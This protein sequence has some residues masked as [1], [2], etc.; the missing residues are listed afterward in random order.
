MVIAA[1]KGAPLTPLQLQKALFLLGQSYPGEVGRDFYDFQPY[2][3][4]PF[5]VLVYHDA[6]RLADRGLIAKEPAGR[7]WEQFSATM[8]GITMAAVKRNQVPD[9]VMK[10]LEGVVHWARSL[11]FR[12]LVNAIYERYPEQ[13]VNSVFRG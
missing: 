4:G 10:Y 5:D 3:Y 13:R 11:S 1:A 7:G 12:E 6:E 9:E 2:N 8:P